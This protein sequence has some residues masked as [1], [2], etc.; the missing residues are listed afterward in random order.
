M[1]T[2]LEQSTM[3]D[4]RSA[5]PPRLLLAS[6][7]LLVLSGVWAIGDEFDSRLQKDIADTAYFKAFSLTHLLAY[8]VLAVALAAILQ[9]GWAG[10]GRLLRGVVAAGALLAVCAQWYVAFVTPLLADVAAD[11]VNADEGWVGG[12]LAVSLLSMAV[13]LLYLGISVLRARVLGRR[14]GWLLVASGAALVVL[15]GAQLLIGLALLTA[16]PAGRV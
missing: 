9:R 8:G 4:T 1:T 3:H 5:A 10:P 6:G 12:G 2:V 16:R 14:T 13:A 7:A 11:S 15:P